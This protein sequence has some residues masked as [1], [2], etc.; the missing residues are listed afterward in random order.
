[1]FILPVAVLYGIALLFF[2]VG[3]ELTPIRDVVLQQ[4]ATSTILYRLAYDDNTFPYKLAA[5]IA[6]NPEVIALGTSRAMQFR[7]EF[8]ANPSTFYNAGGMHNA[9]D[10]VAFI[11]SLPANSKL[12]LIIVDAELVF[13]T[14]ES[15]PASPHEDV[16][17]Y[18]LVRNF[19]THGWRDVYLGYFKGKFTFS[20]LA[21]RARE[22]SAIG[23]AALTTDAGFR[24][25]GSYRPDATPFD[26]RQAALQNQITLALQAISSNRNGAGSSIVPSHVDDLKRFLALC[27][28]RGIEVVGYIPPIEQE[29][30]D[31][32]LVAENSFGETNRAAYGLLTASFTAY[33]YHLYD[34]S[35]LETIGSSDR[36]LIDDGHG[37]EKTYLRILSYLAKRD[38]HLSPFVRAD[39]ASLLLKTTSD[40]K[41]L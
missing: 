37:S 8:F 20:S 21:G 39:A 28:T 27:R 33:G 7:S 14:S 32:T 16:T 34:V 26:V 17:A 9:A 36:E 3:R 13:L 11:T 2:I 15:T 23:V 25:D 31:A 10:Y 6:R 38:P 30:H 19:F 40:I 1:M 35:S 29:E 22:S 5:T 4:Q 24:N 41:V 18:D 12:K